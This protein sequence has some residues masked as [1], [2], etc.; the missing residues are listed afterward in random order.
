MAS[1]V[2]A[3]AAEQGDESGAMNEPARHPGDTASPHPGQAGADRGPA[4]GG[5]AE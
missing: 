4:A 3:F 5:V 1:A 2:T